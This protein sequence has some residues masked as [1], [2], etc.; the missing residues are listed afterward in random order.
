MMSSYSVFVLL[1]LIVRIRE[2]T[3]QHWNCCIT[4]RWWLGNSCEDSTLGQGEVYNCQAVTANEPT[5]ERLMWSVMT[6][7]HRRGRTKT[8][9]KHLVLMEKRNILL[10]P[11][12]ADFHLRQGATLLQPADTNLPGFSVTSTGREACL[13]QEE[14]T[15]L[16]QN[17]LLSGCW[18]KR[19]GMRDTFQCETT[20]LN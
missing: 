12:E 13:L 4:K 2:T 9:D 14:Q 10:Y 7:R 17:T 5:T 16:Q 11:K 8:C 3:L 15:V 1:E 6:F 20:A 18:H 19:T